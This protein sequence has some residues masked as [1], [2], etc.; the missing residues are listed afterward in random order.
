[1]P[2][3]LGFRSLCTM[4]LREVVLLAQGVILTAMGCVQYDNFAT[5]MVR[6]QGGLDPARSPFRLDHATKSDCLEWKR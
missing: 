4:L 5:C 2:A 3:K 1:M 6:L